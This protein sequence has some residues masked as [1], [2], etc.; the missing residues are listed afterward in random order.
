MSKAS[1]SALIKNSI[2]TILPIT[3]ILLI[4]N[5]EERL[6]QRLLDTCKTAVSKYRKLNS[7]KLVKNFIIVNFRIRKRLGN[8]SF[9]LGLFMS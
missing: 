1:C 2:A 6:K 7:V 9:T 3:D 8:A 4:I 5:T